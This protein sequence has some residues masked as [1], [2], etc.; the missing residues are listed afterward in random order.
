VYGSQ[1]LMLEKDSTSRIVIKSEEQCI[2]MGIVYSPLEIDTDGETMRPEVIEKMAHDFLANGRVDRID[3]MHD[4]QPTASR[5]VESFIARKNDPHDFPEGAWVLAV[6]IFDPDLWTRVKSGEINGFSFSGPITPVEVRGVPVKHIVKMKGTTEP[7]TGGPVPEHTH[8]V[9]LQFNKNDKVIPVLTKEALG[10]QHY[11]FKTT[12]TEL[13]LDH[14][15][16]LI[17]V[18]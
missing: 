3:L 1:L 12:A 18:T 4:R 15:H 8:K 7:S 13:A 2:V 9:Q 6:K 11:V 10:H 16:R 14:A 5:V 17:L